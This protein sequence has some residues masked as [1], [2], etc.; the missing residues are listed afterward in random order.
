MTA[1]KTEIRIT[2]DLWASSMLPE[3]IIEKWIMPDGAF[4]ESGEPVAAIRIEDDIIA[5]RPPGQALRLKLHSMLRLLPLA[6]A[7][8]RPLLPPAASAR[9]TTGST[10]KAW[11]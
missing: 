11:R 9:Q 2:A 7:G 1:T 10:A 3:G 6:R 8:H 4:V 5:K